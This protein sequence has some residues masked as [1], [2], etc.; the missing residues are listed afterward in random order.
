MYGRK[1]VKHTVDG[2][3]IDSNR[4]IDLKDTVNMQKNTEK[5][6]LI[7]LFYS[8][9]LLTRAN[10]MSPNLT[11][12]IIRDNVKLLKGIFFKTRIRFMRTNSMSFRNS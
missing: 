7:L 8:Q 10:F 2:T 11:R 5:I 1:A 3:V 4:L 9:F 6:V 12:P